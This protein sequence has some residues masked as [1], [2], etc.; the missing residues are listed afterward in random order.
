MDDRLRV[1]VPLQRTTFPLWLSGG[2]APAGGL[3]GIGGIGGGVG[4]GAGGAGGGSSNYIQVTPDE[5]LAIERLKDLG[6]P[7]ALV[8]Q[9]RIY[10]VVKHEFY[11]SVGPSDGSSVGWYTS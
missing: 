3:G 9:V 11:G 4:G 6:F 10:G 2:V 1:F 5:K 7:E 8:I